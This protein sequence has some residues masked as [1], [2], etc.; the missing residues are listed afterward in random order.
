MIENYKTYHYKRKINETSLLFEISSI[1]CDSSDLH[2]IL[3]QIIDKSAIKLNL[4]RASISILNRKTGEILID[5][6]YGFSNKEKSKGL[7]KK[8]EGVTGQ[9]VKTGEPI[10]IEN[11]AKNEN[12]LNH[13]KAK[14]EDETQ[15]SYICVPIKNS[16]DVLGTIGAYRNYKDVITLDDDV[17]FLSIVAT[18]IAQAVKLKQIIKE[19]KEKLE[20]ENLRLKSE[21]KRKF[22]PG[23][24]IGSS[25]QMVGVFEQISQ[26]AKSEATVLIRGESG[27]GKELVA[28][29]L[30]FNSLREKMPFVKVNCAALPESLI[31]SELFGHEAGAFTGAVAQRKGR[32]ELADRGTIFLD[33]IGE[34]SPLMQVKILRV[35]QEK[36]FERVGG[37][38]TIRV[39]VR[40]I[41]ATNRN[42]EEEMKNSTF[43]E[44]LFYRLNVFPIIIPQLRERK[45]D[46]TQ[47]VDFFIEKYNK[48]NNSDIKRISS[49]AIDLLMSYHW[50]GNI[51]E[52]E[53]IIERASIVAS[54]S[55]IHSHNLPPTLQSEKSSHTPSNNK[56]PDAISQFEKEMIIKELK[57]VDGNQSK[58]AKNLGITERQIG[59]RIDKYKIDIKKFKH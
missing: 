51:R 58:A 4:K 50:P 20:Q 39:N 2:K 16:L 53:N 40:I 11:I 22:H 3:Q 6:A 26:V 54:S 47:L 8:G 44:D 42:L 38:K 41:A 48:Q 33:E 52:L 29:A 1:L 25:S 28:N 46:I 12:F 34:L 57:K 55:V 36:E 14:N 18:M 19:E 10:V 32:F 37:S 7:Y 5:S 56:L 43:R 15:M 24:M 59:C 9:V 30:H 49:N 13:T 23:N 35:L 17:R 27:T 31:E 21:I 45:S